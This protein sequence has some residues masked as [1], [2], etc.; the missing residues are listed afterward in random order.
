MIMSIDI[1]ELARKTPASGSR[2]GD[3]IAHIGSIFTTSKAMESVRVF[4]DPLVAWAREEAAHLETDTP[5]P[6][7]A[8]GGG[9][10]ARLARCLA[11]ISRDISAAHPNRKTNMPEYV[12][13]I[14]QSVLSEFFKPSK[15]MRAYSTLVVNLRGA[16][17]VP[18]LVSGAAGDA[19][20]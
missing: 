9:S 18:H 8:P 6:D 5:E 11:K 13:N 4:H 16:D 20:E 12:L 3:L 1:P 7:D 19:L 14:A 2:S 15:D 10:R 17:I